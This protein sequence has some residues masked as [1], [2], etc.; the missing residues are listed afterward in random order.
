MDFDIIDAHTHVHSLPNHM[1]DSPPERIVKLM[2]EANISRAIIMPYGEILPEDLSLLEYTISSV[3]KYPQR[4]IGFARMHPGGG[5]E[6]VEIFEKSVVEDGIRGLKFHPVG[7]S[8]HPADPLSVMFVKKACELGIPTLFHCGDEEWTLPLQIARLLKKVPEAK[9]ILG[10]MGGYFHVEDAIAVAKDY[11]N[12]Y[13]ETS[14][15][16]NPKI[17]EKAVA[18]LGAQRVIFGSDGPGCLPKLEVE[19]ITVLHLDAQS[20]KQIFHDNIMQLLGTK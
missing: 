11:E 13:L 3:K 9:V 6:G 7:T 15:T 19:K 12:C 16:P 2:D 5:K 14:A 8:I 17:I 4:L 10:H 20:E 18:E 1:W